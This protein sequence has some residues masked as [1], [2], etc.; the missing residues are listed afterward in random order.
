[1]FLRSVLEVLRTILYGWVVALVRMLRALFGGRRDPRSERDKRAS[2]SPCVP[3]AD[4]AFVRPDPLIYSQQ[5]LMA[6][7]LA[8]TWD[9]PDIVL[10]R[11]G[12]PV[13]SHELVADTDYEV[14]ARCWNDSFDAPAIN[15]GV[16][17]SYLDFGIGT[18]PTAI[19]STKVDIGVKGSATQPAF[20][21]LQ[22]R[23]PTTPGHYCLQVLLD[24][25]DDRDSSNN[26]GQENTNVGVAASPVAFTLRN[27][28]PRPHRY[29][30]DV[31]SYQLR[32][33]PCRDDDK[34]RLD[35]HRREQHRI[36][37]GWK[38]DIVPDQ[39]SLDPGEQTPIEVVI[40]PPDSYVGLQPFNIDAFH[41]R[42]A[43]GG[44]TLTVKGVG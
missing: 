13:A 28:D 8:V 26:L 43:A 4:P 39:P 29:R 21:S 38:V 23:T 37:A 7:G 25:V 1:M 19:G 12:V 42:G 10:Y 34:D 27:D 44:V 5:R 9:N 22:W 20:A 11:H 41:E 40:T 17:L 31:T 16:H 15:C 24:P 30:F 35:R 32:R 3:I 14:R 6:L 2:R 33:Q 36:P 18:T